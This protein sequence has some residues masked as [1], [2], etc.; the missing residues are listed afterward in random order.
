MLAGFHAVAARLALDAA[1]I[2]LVYVDPER[3]DR[4]MREMRDKLFAAGVRVMN[5]DPRRL[6]GLSPEVPH[7][8]IV[9][10]AAERENTLDF[11]D[12]LDQITPATLLLILDGVTDPRNF[13]AC[14]RAAD[15]AGVQA[16]I[17]PRDRSARMTPAAA[18][19]AAGAAETVPVVQVTNLASAIMELRDNGVFVAGTAGETES[20]IYDIDQARAFAW[21]LGAEGEGLRQ[22]T[23]RRCDVLAAIPM[24]GSVE[25]LNVS[26]ASGICLFESLR[27]RIA[28][29][30][31]KPGK[32]S[33]RL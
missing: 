27:Q 13:G 17:V 29:G 20:S 18:K 32:A 21:V 26:V 7:Q 5:A 9:A 22:L 31:V 24:V 11:A 28:A 19:A 30:I 33:E 6:D 16:V 8:G 3:R 4:R 2:E 14:L 15:A 23:R 1:S 10:L 25:S 12:L